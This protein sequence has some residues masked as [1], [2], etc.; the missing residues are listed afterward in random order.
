M[1][2][3]RAGYDGAVTIVAL[4]SDHSKADRAVDALLEH[5]FKPEQITVSATAREGD[6]Y[7]DGS[8]RVQVVTDN[9]RDVALRIFEDAGALDIA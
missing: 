9:R 7:P 4:F 8:V 2:T 3:Q 5:H 6:P 1:L